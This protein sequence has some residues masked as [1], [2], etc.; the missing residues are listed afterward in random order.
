VSGHSA[1]ITQLK[2]EYDPA[3]S[4]NATLTQ[5]LQAQVESSRRLA[6]DKRL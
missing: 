1:A 6:R 2:A 5:W 3:K 4:A